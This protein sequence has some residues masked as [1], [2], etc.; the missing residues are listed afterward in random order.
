MRF[1]SILSA[2]ACL[3]AVGSIALGQSDDIQSHV[4]ISAVT[5]DDGFGAALK[6]PAGI[7]YQKSTGEVYVADAGNG[8]IVIFDSLLSAIFSFKHFVKDVSS[9][10]LVVGQPRGIVVNRDDE[11]LLLD[12]R[13]EKLELLDFR[14]RPITKV[15]PNELLNKPASRSVNL[16]AT[17]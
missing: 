15:A 7:W 1:F 3:T 14:G 8:R 16:A 13:S 9:G 4:Q 10:E 11:M 5:Y 17:I 2:L 12:G 6:E